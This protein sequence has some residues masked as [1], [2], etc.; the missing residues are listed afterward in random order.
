M[1]LH[2]FTY[3]S[4]VHAKSFQLCLTLLKPNGLQPARL[5]CPWDFLGK[6]TVVGC[7]FLLRGIFL[8]QGSNLCPLHWQ[9]IDFIGPSLNMLTA[10]RLHCLSHFCPE[11]RLLPPFL[12]VASLLSTWMGL[13][14]KEAR[15]S[16]GCSSVIAQKH[17]QGR[18][19]C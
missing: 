3:F 16:S 15:E 18:L 10:S 2:S 17:K 6:N 8:T 19:C 12:C 4:C 5:L 7:H 14:S 9:Q 13:E 1:H 11:F